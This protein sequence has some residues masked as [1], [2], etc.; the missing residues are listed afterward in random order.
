M[1][2]EEKGR[3]LEKYHIAV[4]EWT[5]MTEQLN[6]WPYTFIERA[7]ELRDVAMKAKAAYIDHKSEHGC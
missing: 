2:C 5:Q 7:K 3:L 4:S 1:E 6:A